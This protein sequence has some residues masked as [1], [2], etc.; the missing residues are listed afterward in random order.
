MG[1][2]LHRD[3]KRLSGNQ[4]PHESERFYDF[5][6]GRLEIIHYGNTG[7]FYRSENK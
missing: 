5:T 3:Y 1:K 4:V 2:Y 7:A 6:L